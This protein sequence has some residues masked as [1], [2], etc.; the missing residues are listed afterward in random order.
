MCWSSV[1]LAG[2][3]PWP[4]F[5]AASETPARS[6]IE[7][8]APASCPDASSVAE[9]LAAMRG[10]EVGDLRGLGTVRGVIRREGHAWQLTLELLDGGERDSRLIVADAC[11]DLA[12]AAAVAL[13]LALDAGEGAAETQRPSEPQPEDAPPSAPG[14]LEPRLLAHALLDI[15]TL[16]RPAFG[17]G[18]ELR[19]ELPAWAFGLY[20]ALLPAQSDYVRTERFVELSLWLAGAH[21]C[22]RL[23]RAPLEGTA[24]LG[25]E[26]GL[27]QAA[28]SG[29]PESR[30]AKDP[31]L[32]PNA[33]VELG[34]P[35]WHGLGVFARAEVVA[36][37][38]RRPYVINQTEAVH[39]P[40]VLV[41]RL[42]AGL[43]WAFE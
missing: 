30:Q 15:G 23:W 36:P 41:P 27:L 33:G 5:A 11:E 1:V 26:A 25:F 39:R 17:F 8:D 12:E 9:R 35:I 31:W 21:A 19:A 10:G 2:L 16:P 24:C 20:A 4:A 13:A 40:S 7:W 6:L 18:A 43:G 37:L 38:V 42:A 28:G 29:L 22:R 32:A 14:R 3:G 34:M